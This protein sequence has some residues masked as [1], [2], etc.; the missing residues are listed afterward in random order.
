MRLKMSDQLYQ[1]L[2]S[3][4]IL[5]ILFLHKD[6]S[7]NSSSFFKYKYNFR[8]SLST[9]SKFPHFWYQRVD[10]GIYERIPEMQ[11]TYTYAKY[12]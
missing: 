4:D 3:I 9:D 1:Q 10:L 2:D 5:E 11:I 6:Y 8:T 7:G 12:S